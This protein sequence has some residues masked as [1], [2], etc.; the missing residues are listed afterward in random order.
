MNQ[1]VAILGEDRTSQ[2]VVYAA[3]A[4]DP[5]VKGSLRLLEPVYRHLPASLG[6][7]GFSSF[8]PGMV[9]QDH[10]V[11]HF[12]S[13]LQLG[14]KAVTPYSGKVLNSEEE[15]VDY[16]ANV[17]G[18]KAY[19]TNWLLEHLIMT[20]E[21][22]PEGIFLTTDLS[23]EQAK[24]LKQR[25]GS[26]FSAI[27]LGDETKGLEAFVNIPPQKSNSALKRVAM[28]AFGTI[29]TQFNPKRK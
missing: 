20:F 4:Q 6:L 19:G 7:I 24:S 10:H 21:E 25:L 17:V 8:K 18:A 9:V 28:Q 1:L 16:F 22:Q 3:L 29:K 5:A 15:A 23:V 11:R 12:F 27:Y 2:T 13:K 26:S 14:V